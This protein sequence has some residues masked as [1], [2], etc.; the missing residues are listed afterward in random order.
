MDLSNAENARA[1][2]LG[3]RNAP[4]A[5]YPRFGKKT[6]NG[7]GVPPVPAHPPPIRAAA[8]GRAFA[9][10]GFRHSPGAVRNANTRRGFVL[11]ETADAG[12]VRFETN[13]FLIA[14]PERETRPEEVVFDV[15]EILFRFEN[16]VCRSF[17]YRLTRPGS[18]FWQK[19]RFGRNFRV[20]NVSFFFFFPNRIELDKHYSI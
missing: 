20:E 8:T 16:F 19:N 4:R 12:S 10:L 13:D 2:Y 5:I 3:H 17:S 1:I 14:K 7:N 15:R 9:S 6:K 11:A 18:L